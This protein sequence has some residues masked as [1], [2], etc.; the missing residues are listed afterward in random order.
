M[1]KP[2]GHET[3]SLEPGGLKR[4]FEETGKAP[5]KGTPKSARFRRKKKPKTTTIYGGG[6]K[7][8]DM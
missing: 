3:P 4:E 8:R 7:F 5:A 1:A 6:D 2:R